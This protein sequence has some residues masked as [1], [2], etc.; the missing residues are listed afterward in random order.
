MGAPW[1]V[2]IGPDEWSREVADGARHARAGAGGG[3]RS[4]AARRVAAPD[5]AHGVKTRA[6]TP[7][8]TPGAATFAPERVGE[9]CASP[10]GS[11]G[12]AT[13]AASCSS[14]CATARA[15]CR[16]SSTPSTRRRRTPPP[17]VCARE[18]VISRARRGRQPLRGDGQP[19]A[20]PT[21][22]VEIRVDELAVLAESADAS[23]PARRGSDPS[24]RRCACAT[25]TSTCAASRCSEP[26]ELRH[27]VIVAIRES[28]QRTRLPRYRDADPDPLDARGRT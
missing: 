9:T 24:T 25:A 14:T 5:G 6:P 2:I 13:T 23:L 16:S 20:L 18:W 15:S 21:G 3:A 8:A 22:E 19:R 17:T 28:P 12:A 27:R 7:T 11:T 10:A 4:I 26:L 1:V